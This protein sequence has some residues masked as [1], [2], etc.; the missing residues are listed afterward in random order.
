MRI[1]GRGARGRILAAKTKKGHRHKLVT[2][3]FISHKI[4]YTTLLNV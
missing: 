4:A 3:F 1:T 2:P